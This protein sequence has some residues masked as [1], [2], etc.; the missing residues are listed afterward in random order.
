MSHRPKDQTEH[1]VNRDTRS[2]AERWHAS[3]D[4]ERIDLELR[5]LFVEVT[6]SVSKNVPTGWH[7]WAYDVR[8]GRMS[9]AGGYSRFLDIVLFNLPQ[10]GHDKARAFSERALALHHA[11]HEARFPMPA[12]PDDP[13]SDRTAPTHPVVSRELNRRGAS[14][15]V[16]GSYD[17]HGWHEVRAA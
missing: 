5:A 4:V 2:G 1:T 11:L 16:M 13:T 8:C 17:V 3:V 14:G 15:L 7:Q 12:G 9:I 6:G 10:L